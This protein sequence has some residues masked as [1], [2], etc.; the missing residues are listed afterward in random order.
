M[1]EDIRLANF[2]R[3]KP[4]L[5]KYQPPLRAISDFEGRYE[6]EFDKDYTT[7]SL[8]T[9]KVTKKHGMY[10][11]A[12]IVQ[13]NYVGFYFMPIYS[14]RCDFALSERMEKMLKGKSCF[15]VEKLDAEL[16][17]EIEKLINKG[18]GIY[19]DF[20]GTDIG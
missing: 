14:H 6:L 1:A 18:Y 16:M 4:L 2:K 10:F 13:S 8:K 15:H 17:K 9:G 19:K 3:L 7:R 12:L 5:A 11:A 20:D